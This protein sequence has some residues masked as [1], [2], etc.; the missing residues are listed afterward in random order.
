MHSYYHMIIMYAIAYMPI[1]NA[2]MHTYLVL[3]CV[4]ASKYHAYW[5]IVLINTIYTE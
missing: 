1:Y 2:V 4:H 3:V 5:P